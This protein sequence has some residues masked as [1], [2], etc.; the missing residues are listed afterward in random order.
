MALQVQNN[1]TTKTK[2]II[3]ALS[4]VAAALVANKALDKLVHEHLHRDGIAVIKR[5]LMRWI[6]GIN[7][8]EI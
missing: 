6:H 2:L 5:K 1:M 4:G 8:K 7:I 3:G